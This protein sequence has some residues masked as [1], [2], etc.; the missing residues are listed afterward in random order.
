MGD[1]APQLQQHVPTNTPVDAHR[2]ARAIVRLVQCSI[3]SLPLRLPVTLP[4][5]NSLCRP[6]LPESHRREYITYPM[7]ESRQHGFTCPFEGCGVEHSLGDC[8]QDVTLSKVMERISIEVARSRR[9]NVDTPT[10]LEEYP[11]RGNGAEVPTLSY[12]PRSRTL[13]GG[14]LLS[15]YTMVEL[16]ELEFSSEVSYKPLSAL[17]DD[18]HQ[19]DNALLDQ[20]KESARNELE[21]Q[22]C[23]GLMLDPVTT[24]CGHSF[25]R[26]C[27]A[28]VL[29]H[30]RLCPI[31]RSTLLM[32][33]GVQQEPSNK[34]LSQLLLQLCPDQIASRLEAATQEESNSQDGRNVPLFPCTLAFP[35]I[36]TF[37]YIFE[38]RYR[39]MIRRALESGDRKFGMLMYNRRGLPQGD[40]GITQFTLFGTLLQIISVE[41]LPDGRSLIETRGVSRFRVKEW[42]MLDG[43]IVG[44]LERHDDVS[45]AE[46]EQLEAAEM[47]RSAGQANDLIAQLDRTSTSDLL[48]IGTQFVTRM[49]AASAPWLREQVIVSYGPPP[50][51]PA[52]FPYWFASILPIADEE[53]YK[54]LSTTSVRERLKITARWIRRIEAQQWWVFLFSIP[55][56]FMVTRWIQ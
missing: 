52:M 33:P 34:R 3:C 54:L 47:S 44:N 21:C 9:L 53:K 29:D 49:R 32:R 45:L 48:N 16:G 56:V 23:Y 5:G 4:C 31:C 41:M 10:L 8:N 12:A 35:G 28:R 18:Y 37:L 15:T 36:P 40:L 42:S 38:P 6:C 51:D 50:N 11:L 55:L 26:K 13:N 22:V 43:Y 14:R 20:L 1:S 27:V 30:S 24:T 25:C 19:L 17:G 2:D 39:L 7:T 46:E